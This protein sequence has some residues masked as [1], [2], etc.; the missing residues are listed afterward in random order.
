MKQ[1]A[2]WPATDASGT[3]ESSY[4]LLFWKVL[5]QDPTWASHVQ[6]LLNTFF[7]FTA[8]IS[9]PADSVLAII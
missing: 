4:C 8:Q 7:S 5:Y 9:L 2:F 1:N 3:Q 6:F